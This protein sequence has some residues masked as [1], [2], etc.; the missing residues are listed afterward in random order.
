[1][2]RRSPGCRSC[3]R[4]LDI[5]QL[6]ISG[7]HRA[8]IADLNTQITAATAARETLFKGE[9]LRGLLLTSYGFSVFGVKGGQGA[10]VA[11]LVSGLMLLLSLAGLYHAAKTPRDKAF[12]I[13]EATHNGAGTKKILIDA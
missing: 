5:P 11:F 8:K 7:Y 10:T 2:W 4:I 3:E 6:K 13:P 9:T 1:M 12:A